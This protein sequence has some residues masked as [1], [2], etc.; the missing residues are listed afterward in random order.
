M[1]SLSRRTIVGGSFNYLLMKVPLLSYI[2]IT[3]GFTYTFYYIFAN[4]YANTNKKMC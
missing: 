2:F 1:V 3:G 4:K